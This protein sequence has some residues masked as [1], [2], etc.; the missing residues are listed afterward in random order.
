MTAQRLCTASS[1]WSMESSAGLEVTIFIPGLTAMSGRSFLPHSTKTWPRNSAKSSRKISRPS[2]PPSRLLKNCSTS[3]AACSTKRLA[4]ISSIS[5]DA[6]F[7]PSILVPLTCR[8]Q[9]RTSLR[10]GASYSSPASF[11]SGTGQVLI[12]ALVGSHYTGGSTAVPPP[13]R[14]AKARVPPSQHRAA[15]W[16]AH[17]LGA[18][19]ESSCFFLTIGRT[20]GR[21]D[22]FRRSEEKL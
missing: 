13:P 10:G 4:P 6:L 2:E 12:N 21:V 8:L 18:V 20:N 5:C 11:F 19:E 17:G 14:H 9:T 22:Y 15:W 3:R 7:L 16:R 1:C